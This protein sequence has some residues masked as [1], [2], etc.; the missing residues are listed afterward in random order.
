MKQILCISYP[1]IKIP[2][3]QD[4]HNLI[5][6]KRFESRLNHFPCHV[7]FEIGFILEFDYWSV[8]APTLVKDSVRS[9]Y[10][11]SDTVLYLHPIAYMMQLAAPT[12]PVQNMISVDKHI[13]ICVVSCGKKF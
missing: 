8:E 4:R 12:G 9:S 6:I 10:H 7:C 11:S 1:L 2:K 13:K 3:S 5:E